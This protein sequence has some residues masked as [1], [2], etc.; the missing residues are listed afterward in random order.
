MPT[1]VERT[2]KASGGD[3]TSCAAFLAGEVRNLV[4]ADEIARGR[5]FPMLDDGGDPIVSGWTQDATHYV[6]FVVATPHGCVRGQGS[7]RRIFGFGHGFEF[8]QDFCRVDGWA[9]ESDNSGGV[10]A[11]GD[12]GFHVDMG[13][14]GDIR[15]SRMYHSV[16][17][18]N[19][20]AFFRSFNASG[21][22]KIWNC[23]ASADFAQT[24]SFAQAIDIASLGAAYVYGNTV[25]G[26]F[27]G[28]GGH[29]I[30]N[31]SGGSPTI[32]CKNNIAIRGVPVNGNGFDLGGATTTGSTNNLVDATDSSAPGS[33]PIQGNPVFVDASRGDLHIAGADTKC[34]NVGANLSADANIPFAYDIDGTP[35]PQGS[36][37]DVGA[38]EFEVPRPPSR[39][40]WPGRLGA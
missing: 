6:D 12:R 18:T 35:R 34:R 31:T 14:S 39:P 21:G 4:A 5:G 17:L 36:A 30:G 32:V 2:I 29:C 10:T 7:R 19:D 40:S 8:D 15:I 24:G 9:I 33:N 38:H 27:F 16:F 11:P 26:Q 25:L 3:Y 20:Q 28:P 37:W 1:V 22:I 23:M 13:A